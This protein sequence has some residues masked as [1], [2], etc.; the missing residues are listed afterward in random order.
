[1]K[2]FIP[3]IVFGLVIVMIGLAQPVLRTDFTT[4]TTPATR[5]I[6]TNI[7]KGAI[8]WDTTKQPADAV[9]TNFINQPKFTGIVTNANS[10]G[11]TN[12]MLFSAGVLTNVVIGAHP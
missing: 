8:A 3:G 5:T 2:R 4:N 6:S 7:A 12:F 9:L 11:Q 10:L 1:M